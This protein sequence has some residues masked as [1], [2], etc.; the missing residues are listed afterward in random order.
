MMLD[1][2]SSAVS[3]IIEIDLPNPKKDDQIEATTRCNECG[4]KSAKLKL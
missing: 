3:Q 4:V 2:Q 1:K